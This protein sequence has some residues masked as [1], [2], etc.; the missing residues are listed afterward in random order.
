MG[1]DLTIENERDDG[2]ERVGDVTARYS[3][4]KGVVVPPS[5]RPR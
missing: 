5:A 2:G 3:P 4:L 1:A